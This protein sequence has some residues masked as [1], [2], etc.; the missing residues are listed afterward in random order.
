M[1]TKRSFTGSVVDVDDPRRPLAALEAKQYADHGGLGSS[2][3][4]W[5]A[6]AGDVSCDEWHRWQKGEDGR[7]RS[8]SDDWW[9]KKSGTWRQSDADRR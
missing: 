9:D 1:I 4:G 5:G 8:Q 6:S 7:N 2:K 3:D